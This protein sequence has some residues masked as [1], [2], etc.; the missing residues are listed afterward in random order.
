MNYI[1]A[2]IAFLIVAIIYVIFLKL[3]VNSNFKIDLKIFV[4]HYKK[5]TERKLS[6]IQ[7][8]DKY[9]ITN[10]EFIEIDRDDLETLD[11][12][13]FHD[14]YNNV[15][16][17]ISL[18]HFKAYEEISKKYDEGLILE[19]DVKLSDDFM[20]K[21][22][23]YIVQLPEDYDML[24]IG[25]GAGLHI[26]NH[27]LVPEKNIY[28][29]GLDKTSWGGEG[30]TRCTDSYIVSNNCATGL[31]NYIKNIKEKVNLP[32]DWWLNKPLKENNFNIYWAE[33]TI[34][35]QGTQNGTYTPSY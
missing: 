33:P 30:A 17:A 6:I 22:N 5:L 15:Q 21:L 8:F 1:D 2:I 23:S 19:D 28:K 31:C 35:S 4:I 18:S 13:M 14:D 29:K 9:K 7:Q 20:N 16:R 10:Y 24:F 12:S 34:V 32:I 25:D 27:V 26:E 11:T 3:R